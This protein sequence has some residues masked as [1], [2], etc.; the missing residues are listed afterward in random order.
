MVNGGC[1][2]N[3]YCVPTGPAQMKCICNEN[4]VGDGYTCS[5]TLRQVITTHPSLTLLNSYMNVCRVIIFEIQNFV[6]ST[7]TELL[8][9]THWKVPQ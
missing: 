8:Q 1:G 6:V 9:T 5:G 7:A 4:Y 2:A 3:A